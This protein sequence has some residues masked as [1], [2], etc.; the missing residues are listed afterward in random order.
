MKKIN[1]FK[2]INIVQQNPFQEPQHRRRHRP[3]PGVARTSSRCVVQERSSDSIL[4]F[5]ISLL[6]FRQV[7]RM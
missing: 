5:A 7:K 3:G 4:P 6:T 1:E 2:K